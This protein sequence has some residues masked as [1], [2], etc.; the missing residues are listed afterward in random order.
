MKK[1]SF[2]SLM[3]VALL[4]AGCQKEMVTNTI[5]AVAESSSDNDESKTSLVN[6]SLVKWQENDEIS[7]RSLTS[8]K[9]VKA[10]FKYSSGDNKA[11]FETEPVTDKYDQNTRFIA[12]FPYSEANDLGSGDTLLNVRLDIPTEQV[13][14]GDETFG[15]TA[16]PMVAHGGTADGSLSRIQFHSLA[17]LARIQMRSTEEKNLSSITF[18][19]VTTGTP[20]YIAG[21][22]K[23]KDYDQHDPYLEAI[24]GSSTRV[25]TIRFDETFTLG[26]ELK[27]FYLPLPAQKINGH[28]IVYAIRMTVRT[29]DGKEMSKTIGSLPISRNS[30]TRMAALNITSWE[31]GTAEVSIVG[32]GTADR[33]FLIYTT[34]DLVKVR[35][36]F[37][38]NIPLN[39]VN[40]KGENSFCYF[41]IMRSDI[42][43]DAE[44]GWTT[45][46]IDFKGDMSY[47]ANTSTTP[48]ITNNTTIPLFSAIAA[49][50][51][52]SGITVKGGSTQ[53]LQGADAAFSPFCRTNNGTIWNC[54][55]SNDAQYVM[56]SD[57][58]GTVKLAG[59]CYQ[60]NGTIN[61]CGCGGTLKAMNVAG[62]CYENNG[63]IKDCYAASPMK[64]FTTNSSDAIVSASTRAAGICYDNKSGATVEA[65]YY[66]ANA[67]RTLVTS[68]GGIAYQNAG[69]VKKC[70]VANSGVMQSTTSVGGIVHTMT[71]GL[72]DGCQNEADVMNVTG[73]SAGLGGIVNTLSGGEVRNC[74][75]YNVG[76]SFTCT[77]GPIGGVVATMSGSDTKVY[78]SAYYGDMSLSNVSVKGAFVGDMQ[79]GLIENCYAIQ[80][81]ALGSNTPFY[82]N[83]TGGTLTHCYGQV[84]ATGVALYNAST[85]LGG[86]NGWTGAPTANTYCKWVQ[87]D[88]NPPTFSTSEYF[89]AS[90]KRR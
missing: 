15:K 90:K 71:G 43:L 13:Y 36:A 42:T 25:L 83:K 50:S 29:T 20:R 38:G 27:S 1:F 78:N 66:A 69:T 77:A 62:I 35:D 19:E 47:A 63:T 14:A 79:N 75:R 3:L 2:L 64:V 80:N 26:N 44:Q 70:Y 81:T 41:R 86:L 67:S 58:N 84:E 37:N 40:L 49:G 54:H 88:G 10:T 32:N 7:V 73:G 39:G 6:E 87:A 11:V 76:G 45:Y 72:L 17:G 31:E 61:G 12:L 22:F 21:L 51:K 57:G 8:N 59:I 56:N 16:L 23:V 46:G 5:L 48:G 4:F 89:T 82:G 9:S 30:I 65:C 53:T 68:W 52:V 33:P 34:A 18:E 85:I 28:D 55:I 60:N 24:S 74:L